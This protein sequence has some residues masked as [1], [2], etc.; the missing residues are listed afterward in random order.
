MIPADALTELIESGG[1]LPLRDPPG[2]VG[3]ICARKVQEVRARAQRSPVAALYQQSAAQ[4]PPRGFAAALRGSKL[5]LIAEMKP[6]SPSRGAIRPGVTPGDIA[7]WYGPHAA[8]ISVLCDGE[9]FGGSH[10]LM[11]E[12]RARVSQPVL[13]KDFFVAPYQVIEARAWG[14]DAVLLMC[15]VLQ[16]DSLRTMLALTHALGMDAL[17]ETHDEAEIAEAV[18]SGAAVIGVNARD[19]RTLDIDLARGRRLLQTVPADRVRVA[20]SGLSGPDDVNAVRGIADACLIGSRLMAAPDPAAAIVEL[21]L[22]AQ[23]GAA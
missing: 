7:D 9:D 17:V 19:L 1:A 16:P 18:E 23:A 2:V 6:R 21:G 13:C 20:E 10:S 11:A 15:S 8:A 4:Q 12:V 3:R 22:G 5:G 14:A